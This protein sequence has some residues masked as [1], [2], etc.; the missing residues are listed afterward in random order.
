MWGNSEA[1]QQ[2][3]NFLYCINIEPSRHTHSVTQMAVHILYSVQ[4]S[5]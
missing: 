4:F 5:I 3:V 2:L 1:T